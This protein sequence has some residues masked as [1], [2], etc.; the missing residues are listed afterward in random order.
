[1]TECTR[2]SSSDDEETSSADINDNTNEQQQQQHQ[3]HKEQAGAEDDDNHPEVE[4]SERTAALK[5][6][7]VKNRQYLIDRTN[8]TSK[9]GD[10]SKPPCCLCY[11]PKPVVWFAY[12][13]EQNRPFEWLGKFG[14]FPSLRA[15]RICIGLGLV[16]NVLCL[17]LSIYV[18][19][20][21]STTDFDLLWITAFT[22][23]HVDYTTIDGDR[24]NFELRVGIRAVAM[25]STTGRSGSQGEE[26]IIPF[27]Q[28]CDLVQPIL[29][30][31]ECGDCD[32]ASASIMATLFISVV[33]C[34]PSITTSVLRLY[35]HY[36]C[37]CQKVFGGFAAIISVGFAIYTFMIYQFRCF[38][39]LGFGSICINPSNGDIVDAFL[40]GVT[41]PTDYVLVQR[42]FYAGPGWI[43]LSTASGLKILDMLFNLAIPTPSICRNADEQREYELL[44]TNI[45]NQ[46]DNDDEPHQ[47]EGTFR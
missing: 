10:G 5:P 11:V 28:F 6:V 25:E 2:N 30:P 8:G 43:A 27:D 23:G 33:M 26:E 41:C 20:A 9:L 14:F 17:G 29:N 24:Q 34:I 44:V 46:N 7:V 31:G 40:N 15:R 45:E 37:N 1:V 19:F 16:C 3:Q 38:R 32:A 21:I 18:C 22:S 47:E 13:I 42:L 35:P 12:Y 4:D 36:D 39:S